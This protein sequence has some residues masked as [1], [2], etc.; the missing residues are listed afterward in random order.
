VKIGI[1][2]LYA[3]KIE[4][5]GVVLKIKIDKANFLNIQTTISAKEK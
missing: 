5:L 1:Y 2:I 4:P 3:N